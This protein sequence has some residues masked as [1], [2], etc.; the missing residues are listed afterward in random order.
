MSGTCK[1]DTETS[2]H[3]SNDKTQRYRT[4]DSSCADSAGVTHLGWANIV[5]HS[6]IVRFVSSFIAD[7]FEGI[8]R[9]GTLTGVDLH[10][11]AVAS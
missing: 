2:D 7:G 9:I 8:S 1:E 10:S 3:Q 4:P 5:D 11:Y 6:Q